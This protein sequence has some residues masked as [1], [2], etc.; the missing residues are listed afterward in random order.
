MMMI[1]GHSLSNSGLPPD[2][3]GSQ[4]TRHNVIKN[5]NNK[6]DNLK[7][8]ED[9]KQNCDLLSGQW[10]RRCWWPC[11]EDERKVSTLNSIEDL[12]AVR[13]IH[14]SFHISEINLDMVRV[15]LF[16]RACRSFD[17][18]LPVCGSNM[19]SIAIEFLEARILAWSSNGTRSYVL[20]AINSLTTFAIRIKEHMSPLKIDFF[21]SSST[22]IHRSL[23][24][25]MRKKWSFPQTIKEWLLFAINLTIPKF[26]CW[27]K[28]SIKIESEWK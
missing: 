26:A 15:C 20:E 7:I 23:K 22:Y 18:L 11:N 19:R 9:R 12:P 25:T 21:P 16:F 4:K 2:R 3:A 13:N 10:C 6:Y 14:S 24:I 5:K 17:G 8:N 28:W 1:M 27:R